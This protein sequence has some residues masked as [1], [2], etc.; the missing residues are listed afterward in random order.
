MEIS[1]ATLSPRAVMAYVLVVLS[2]LAI[3]LLAV[4]QQPA[5]AAP[6]VPS[7]SQ[8]HGAPAQEC[9]GRGYP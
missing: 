1:T 6:S 4:G 5:A 3:L 7:L 8:A 2:A 9:C